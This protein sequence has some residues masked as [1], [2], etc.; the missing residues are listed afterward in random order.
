MVVSVPTVAL[1]LSWLHEPPYTEP[2][3]RWCGGTAD[4]DS[5]SYPIPH[6]E[7]KELDPDY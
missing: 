7:N 3:V 2:Y 6:P 1:A 5:V 4:G